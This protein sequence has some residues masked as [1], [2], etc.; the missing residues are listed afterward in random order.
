VNFTLHSKN[1][2]VNESSAPKEDPPGAPRKKVKVTNVVI[3]PP[4]TA[5]NAAQ[6]QNDANKV[7]QA[8][9][10]EP[11]FPGGP[12]AFSSFLARTVKYPAVDR[13]NKVSGKVYVSFVV[14]KDGTITDIR[15]VRGPSETLKEEAVRSIKTS[16]RWKPGIQ[17]GKP[18]RVQYTIPVNFA[19]NNSAPKEDAPPATAKNTRVQSIVLGPSGSAPANK[20]YVAV[21]HEPEFPGGPDAFNSFLAN[22]IKYPAVDR[23]HKVSGKVYIA[24]VVEMDGSLTDIKAIRGPSETLKDEAI[25][26]LKASPK[27]KPGVQNGQAVR[28]QYTV[29]VNFAL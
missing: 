28:V 14:E 2:L 26:A 7:Y 16:P 19:L 10:V 22:N 13:D 20:V 1:A 29:P 5:A 21:E 15:P 6:V 18:V 27:W 12:D 4:A 9:E 25:H 3:T 17:N 11:S 24:F 23:D 8:V